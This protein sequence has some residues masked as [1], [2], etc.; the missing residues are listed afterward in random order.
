M[1]NRNCTLS[2]P[3]YQDT[4][5]HKGTSF[6]VVLMLIAVAIYFG[7]VEVTLVIS[8]IYLTAPIA[9]HMIARSACFLNVSMWEGKVVEELMDKYDHH[10]HLLRCGRDSTLDNKSE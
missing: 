1:N 4:R 5:G 9:C 6:G 7:N 8:F 2:C 3:V 10:K